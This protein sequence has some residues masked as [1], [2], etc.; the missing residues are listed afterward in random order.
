MKSEKNPARTGI[1]VPS[2]ARTLL[3]SEELSSADR[4]LIVAVL[5]EAS[6]FIG[7]EDVPKPTKNIPAFL[8]TTIKGEVGAMKDSAEERQRRRI[9]SRRTVAGQSADNPGQSADSPRPLNHTL[10]IPLTPN[11]VAGECDEHVPDCPQH[12]WSPGEVVAAFREFYEAYPRQGNRP[13]ALDEWKRAAEAGELP[14]PEFVM[15][16]LSA[17]KASERWREGTRFIP[18]PAKFVAGRMWNDP[19]DGVSEKN[20]APPDGAPEDPAMPCPPT[21]DDL[22]DPERRAAFLASPAWRGRVE[23][24]CRLN[25]QEEWLAEQTAGAAARTP[26]AAHG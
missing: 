19:P 17:W 1:S 22:M 15:E 2:M 5:A 4:L 8:C 20:G 18:M 9:A 3:A 6:G 24:W 25:A 21:P 23:A 11:G 10:T 26:E 14:A 13:A 7:A 12:V 16:R